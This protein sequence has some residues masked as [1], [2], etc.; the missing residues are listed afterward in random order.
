MTEIEN[1]I[2]YRHGDPL[3]KEALDKG[4]ILYDRHHK[5]KESSFF[6]MLQEHKK[7][8]VDELQAMRSFRYNDTGKGTGAQEEG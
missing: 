8:P 1:E 7:T 2:R 6:G 5:I 3:I 4:T